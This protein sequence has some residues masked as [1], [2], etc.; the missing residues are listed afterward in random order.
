MSR[1]IINYF[2]P[3]VL[4]LAIYLA[5][6]WWQRRRAKK[7]GDKT[8]FVERFHIFI[9]MLIGF[10]LMAGS[11]TWIAMVSGVDPGVGDYQSPR[12]LDGKIIPPSFK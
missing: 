11:L 3:L 7:A 8:H 9:S 4:P 12:Y 6:M 5:Y 10:V 2:L 1:I